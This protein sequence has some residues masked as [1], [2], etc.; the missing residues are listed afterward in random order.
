MANEYPISA[1]RCC[2]MLQCTSLSALTFGRSRRS[3]RRRWSE[4]GAM[5]PGGRGQAKVV[6]VDGVAHSDDGIEPSEPHSA[7]S[8]HLA[9]GA[10]HRYHARDGRTPIGT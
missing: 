3:R 10:V 5:A 4:L 8:D 6:W 1:S 7:L 2:Q 9:G